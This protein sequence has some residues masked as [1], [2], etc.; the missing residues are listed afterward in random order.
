M[1]TL[2][3]RI[4]AG[5]RRALATLISR[6]EKHDPEAPAILGALHERTGRAMVVGITGAPGTGKSTLVAAL[7]GAFRRGTAGHPPRTVGILAVDPTSPFSGG[8]ILGDRIRMRDLA[9][10]EGVFIR[11]MASR[12]RLGG[13]SHATDSAVRALDAAGF[14]TILI[15][16]V[17]VGQDEVDIARQTPTVIV[18]ESPGT[19][20]DIQALKAGILEIADILVVN[21]ADM[22]GADTTFESLCAMLGLGGGE[23]DGW[24]TPVMK[25]TAATG[26]G[27]DA[28]AEAIHRHRAYLRESGEG[29]RRERERAE[30]DLRERLRERLF[31][32]WRQSG[33][34][35]LAEMARKVAARECSPEEAVEELLK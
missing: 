4:A 9:G 26:E 32:R 1:P 29:R 25:T 35:D 13:L 34:M 12:G 5:D 18:V 19:G 31:E 28:L 33:R 21:K 11:S 14:E 16:T 17:G 10:D 8:A 30:A 22:P 6:I 3:E 15:E 23:G 27:V 20:D 7:A 24:K 2:T